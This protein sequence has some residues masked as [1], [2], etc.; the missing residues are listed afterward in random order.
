MG[1]P[2]II[3]LVVGTWAI[4][5]TGLIVLNDRDVPPLV[6][7]VLA[8]VPAALLASLVAVQ[9]VSTDG[10][11]DVD[12]RLAGVVAALVAVFFRA[13]FGRVFLVGVGVTALVRYVAS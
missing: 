2:L 12:A 13:S 6:T 9:T 11:Y 3:A 7:Q 1:W 8:F 4:R 5:A 10:A